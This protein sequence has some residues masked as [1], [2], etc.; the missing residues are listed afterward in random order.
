MVEK[1]E[2]KLLGIILSVIC[3]IIFLILLLYIIAQFKVKANVPEVTTTKTTSTT[4]TKA[5]GYDFDILTE[6]RKIYFN[7]KLIDKKVIFG[8]NNA[9][10]NN[11]NINNVNLIQTEISKF[12]FIYTYLKLSDIKEPIDFD[13]I[14]TY[15][16]KLFNTYLYE[17]NLSNYLKDELYVYSVNEK[18]PGF[19]LK[20]IKEN[21]MVLLLDMVYKD[22]ETCNVNV[23]EYNDNL[24]MNKI[25]LEYELINGSMIYKSFIILK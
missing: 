25:K 12:K 13:L 5:I 24:I 17:N 11:F 23:T 19:C 7:E 8:F 15:S 20:T 10:D 22:E 16:N 18:D 2:S 6:E 3:G 4:T 9:M 1:D 21:G 14:N